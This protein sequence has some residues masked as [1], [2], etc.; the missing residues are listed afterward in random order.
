MSV[1]K[2]IGA[3]IAAL[4]VWFVVATIIDRTVRAAWPAYAVAEPLLIFT[5]PM[6][7]YRLT[8][9]AVSTVVA[10]VAAR[11][12]SVA[13]W[14]PWALGCALILLFLPEHYKIWSRLPAWYHL[15]FLGYLIPLALLGARLRFASAKSA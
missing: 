10:A 9:G 13:R 12:M 11:R 14:L 6:K 7:I 1:L 3:L 2:A 5:L 4:V 15:T 8:L